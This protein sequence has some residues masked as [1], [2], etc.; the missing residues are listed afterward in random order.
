MK[1]V[2]STL[3]GVGFLVLGMLVFS[4]QD[5]TVKGIGGDYPIL[6][7]VLLRTLVALPL[8]LLFFCLE[9][10]R[11]LSKTRQLGLE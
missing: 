6:E 10:G 9:G 11:G 1:P 7:I 8:T 3:Q 2:S 5:V 4:L